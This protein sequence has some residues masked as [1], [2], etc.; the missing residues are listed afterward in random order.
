MK[1]IITTENNMKDIITTENNMNSQVEITLPLTW[2]LQLQKALSEALEP[3]VEID[4]AYVM[5]DKALIK[6]KEHL[7]NAID[8]I[9]QETAPNTYNRK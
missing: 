3:H 6:T 4:S 5:Q 7:K 9:Q 1:D 8:I 2:F